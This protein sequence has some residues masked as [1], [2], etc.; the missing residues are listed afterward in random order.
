LDG[1]GEEKAFFAKRISLSALFATFFWRV[2]PFSCGLQ[3]GKIELSNNWWPTI[4]NTLRRREIGAYFEK[5][6]T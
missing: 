6:S 1:T 4:S 2:W 3:P 5:V